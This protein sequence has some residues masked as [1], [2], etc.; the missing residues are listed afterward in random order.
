[1]CV[2]WWPYVA[3]TLTH[4]LAEYQG[5]WLHE[6][7]EQ[8]W[9]MFQMKYLASLFLPWFCPCRLPW[10]TIKFALNRDFSNSLWYTSQCFYPYHRV[11]RGCRVCKQIHQQILATD[12]HCQGMLWHFVSMSWQYRHLWL[13]FLGG[14]STLVTKLWFKI[15]RTIW[16][17]TISLIFT[18]YLLALTSMIW[19]I[20]FISSR[21]IFSSE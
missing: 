18:S 7:V 5:N 1:M 9:C 12:R 19:S 11:E 6:C 8:T 3:V 13:T 20:T 15:Y 14:L 2:M 21:S 17:F 16:D 4:I 10:K